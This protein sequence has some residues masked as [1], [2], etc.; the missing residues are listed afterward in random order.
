M[1]K[2][3]EDVKIYDSKD[4]IALTETHLPCLAPNV[5]KSTTNLDV[6]WPVK[7]QVDALK[8]KNLNTS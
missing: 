6:I 3:Q 8:L 2:K 7:L 1:E 4:N 5:D